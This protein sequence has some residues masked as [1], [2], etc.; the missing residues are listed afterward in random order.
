MPQLE[1]G[2]TYRWDELTGVVHDEDLGPLSIG[3][4]KSI[5]YWPHEDILNCRP[6]EKFV[7]EYAEWPVERLKSHITENRELFMSH[8]YHR[9][10][11]QT[12]KNL[13][14]QGEPVF[15]IFVQKNDPMNR[16][17]EGMHRSVAF[18]ELGADFIPVLLTKY[19]DW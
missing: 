14:V 18:Y 5:E 16:I 3:F 15:P 9:D 12:I 10:R 13:L 4:P 7:F 17:V 11:I 8:T 2:R 1:V 6:D 19:A